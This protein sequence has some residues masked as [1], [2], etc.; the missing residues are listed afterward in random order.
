MVA[1]SNA[2]FTVTATGVGLLSYQWRFNG[3]GILAASNSSLVL[4]NVQTNDAGSYT[5]LVTNLLGSVTS[6]AATLTVLVP[7]SITSQPASATNEC[8][9]TAT[10]TVTASGTTPLSYQW[11]FN[12]GPVG[13]ATSTNLA[14]ADVHAAQ[15]G[16]YTVV[17]TNSAG[18]ITSS[19]AFLTVA[20]TT[21]P[22]ITINGANPL[23]NAYQAV[24]VDPGATASDA[25]AGS[26]GVATTSTVNTNAIGVYTIQY[27]A[28]DPSGNSATNTRT[29]YVVPACPLITLSPPS[30]PG[31]TVGIPYS[32]SLTA[33]GGVGNYS[34]SLTGGGTPPGLSLSA[35]GLL[36]GTPAAAVTTNFTV[37]ATDTNGCAASQPYT[38][39]IASGGIT[40]TV[41][42]SS[43]TN[44]AG[45]AAMFSASTTA[46]PPVSFGWR[47]N[48]AGLSDDGRI[49]GSGTSNL[50]INCVQPTDAGSYSVIISNA[51]GTGASPPAFLVVTQL[52]RIPDP[53]LEAAVR[54]TLSNFTCSLGSQD[55]QKLT[56]LWACNRQITN[57][58][59]LE[60]ATNLAGLYLNNNAIS[61]LTP[62]QGLTGLSKL[63]LWNNRIGNLASLAGLS[64]LT[65][66]VL[67]G[68]PVTD[69]SPLSGLTNLISLSVKSGTMTNLTSL[70]N[71]T[72]LTSLSLWQNGITDP[73]P[74]VGLTNLRCLDI[75][76]NG[77]TNFAS[78]L[79]GLTNLTS[80]YLGGNGISNVPALQS[81]RQL[82]LLN[83][84]DNSITDLSPL[85]NLSALGY[86]S[87]SRN[88]NASFSVLSH[89]ANLINL[90]LRGNSIRDVGF[91]SG[92]RQLSY[93]D[94]AYNSI[95]NFGP[96]TNATSL[97]SVV[98]AGN[99]LADFSPVGNLPNLSNLWLFDNAI[100]NASFVAS[101]R[102]LN[103]LNLDRNQISDIQ[104]LVGLTNLTGL[105]LSANPIASY[106]ALSVFSNLTSLRLEGNCL[107]E[108]DL[109]AFL[110]S[111]SKMAFLSLN[112]NRIG[113]LS[114]LLGVTNCQQLYVRENR[115]SDLQ[116]LSEPAIPD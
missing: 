113:S 56:C 76:W 78:S 94:L 109:S 67:G 29:V 75:R 115:L 11:Y 38:Q 35:G 107:S 99:P 77:I 61:D 24:F 36:S 34:Y 112:H 28:S 55:M 110:P 20:D 17:V 95:T 15:Q 96:L 69:Y 85:T 84:D 98:L 80:L 42:P 27:T 83:L 31:G 97:S 47:L 90:E 52:V 12:G 51:A 68:Y 93:V 14:M 48:G 72:G 88:T 8:A 57:L 22:M 89:C 30:L 6:T 10:F 54:C 5:V 26:L 3:A 108:A 101:L 81:L 41:T 116:P 7:P 53:Q 65:C 9:S 25:C 74:L 44:E 91:L 71:L 103:H 37:T 58:G 19:P 33:N 45:T 70:Q 86:L 60:W 63:E 40:V 64:N 49:S 82:T 66:L 50:T 114:P 1:G 2:L 79:T 21:P 104:P 92:L 106:A 16:N 32:Q 59:G 102:Q 62:L 4:T 73:S 87:L 100:S 23:T 43:V 105:G 46:A 13:S 39:A 111:L 18:S